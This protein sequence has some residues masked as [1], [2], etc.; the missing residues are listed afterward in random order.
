M[1][2]PA[3]HT[4]QFPCESDA[5]VL[6][7][8]PLIRH[9]GIDRAIGQV[10]FPGSS[11]LPA[12]QSVLA[13]VAL[14]CASIRRYSRD[15]RWCRDRG[16]GLFAGLN[17][18]PE[19][20]WTS[21]C[22]DR[23]TR[24]LHQDLLDALAELRTQHPLVSESAHLDGTTQPHWG[25]DRTLQQPGPGTRHRSLLGCRRPSPQIRTAA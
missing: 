17:V 11:Q 4:E 23:I 22:S 5:G 25:D 21:S 10:G 9:F 24:S 19:S 3:S 14:K 12:L 6:C 18:L 20:A 8:L 13:F 15:D 2:L 16:P 1:L 7:L